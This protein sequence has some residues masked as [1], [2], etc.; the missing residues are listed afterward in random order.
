MKM[1]LI[2]T[3]TMV[4][5]HHPAMILQRNFSL[6]TY[7]STATYNFWEFEPPVPKMNPFQFNSELRNTVQ[8]FDTFFI[9]TA[10]RIFLAEST[11]MPKRNLN[12]I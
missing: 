9:T 6:A 4:T 7:N 12:L 2:F 8:P 5:W 1:D 10:F 3:N 11:T